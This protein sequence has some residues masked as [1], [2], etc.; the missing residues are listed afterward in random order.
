MKSRLFVP[1]LLLAAPLFAGAPQAPRATAV[2]TAPAVPL[3]AKGMHRYMVVRTFPAGAL[4]GLDAAGKR[5]VNKCNSEHG[6]RWVH[7]YANADK[8]K[9]FCIYDS[10][11]EQAIQDAA[12]ANKIPVDYIVEIPVVLKPR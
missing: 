11:S 8:T 9:T 6:V 1:I 5:A 3:P 4:D 10:P 2:D 7:S 12:T